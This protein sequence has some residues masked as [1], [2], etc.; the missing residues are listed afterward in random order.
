MSHRI[1]RFAVL[2]ESSL[3][4]SSKRRSSKK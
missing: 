2:F 4:E 3:F 1:E